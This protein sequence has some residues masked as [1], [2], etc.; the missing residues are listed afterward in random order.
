MALTNSQNIKL[1]T[2]LQHFAL[3]DPYEQAYTSKELKKTNGLLIYILCNHCPY[4]NVMWERL[5]ELSKFANK[6]DIGV[7]G[8]NPN[9]H[10][11]YPEDSP[12]YMKDK[13]EE[14]GVNFPYLIDSKQIVVKSLGATCT[15]EVFLFDKEDELYYHG[16]VDDAHGEAKNVQKEELREA[17]M[18][19]FN[20]A[21]APKTQEPSLGCS[22]KWL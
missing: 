12:I 8:I 20:G 5:V 14:Y 4:T 1:H 7:L 15:P 18:A 3:E 16:R 2:K 11:N 10:P 21:E 9:I 13:I 22:I 19:L 17:L 6:L